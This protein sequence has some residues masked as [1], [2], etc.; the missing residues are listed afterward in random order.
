MK[1]K[2]LNHCTLYIVPYELMVY[3]DVVHV[4]G[5]LTTTMLVVD[6]MRCMDVWDAV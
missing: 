5:C 2:E 4:D 6:Q 1:N 3:D